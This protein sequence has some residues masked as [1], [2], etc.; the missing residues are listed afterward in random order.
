[1]QNENIVGENS[2]LKIQ[3]QGREILEDS[4]MQELKK[5]YENDVQKLG[6]MA[7]Q[8]KIKDEELKALEI[9]KMLLEAENSKIR[10]EKQASDGINSAF[11]TLAQHYTE[12]NDKIAG[13]REELVEVINHL[14]TKFQQL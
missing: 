9:E 14:K 12:F 7:S 3:L 13:S 6:I 10:S 8:F 4:M 2:V 5:S 1:M 11:D